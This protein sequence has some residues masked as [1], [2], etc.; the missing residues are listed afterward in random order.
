MVEILIP[1][2]SNLGYCICIKLCLFTDSF[3]IKVKQK[4]NKKYPQDLLTTKNLGLL[5]DSS[6]QDYRLCQY[7]NILLDQLIKDPK[8]TR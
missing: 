2:D 8:D 7:S 6:P 1:K 5:W 3:T 4:S